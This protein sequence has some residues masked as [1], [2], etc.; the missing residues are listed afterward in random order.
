MMEETLEG[1]RGLPQAVVPLGMGGGG[2]EGK[3]LRMR[4]L[5]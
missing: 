5:L 2:S 3:E 1:D 4:I